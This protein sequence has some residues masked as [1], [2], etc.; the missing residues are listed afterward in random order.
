M[1]TV[2]TPGLEEQI[3]LLKKFDLAAL[4]ELGQAMEQAVQVGAGG[5]KSVAP[6]DSGRLR[7]SITG[8]VVSV[9]A[10][11]VMGVIGT[12]VNRDGFPYPRVL[13]SSDRYH[14][15]AGPRKGQQTKGYFLAGYESVKESVLKLFAQAV[16]AIAARVMRNK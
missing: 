11:H 3:V 9:V 5:V 15:R 6:V 13:N 4:D 1:N 10:P 14:Y 8:Q 2:Q 12:N 16:D 7:S